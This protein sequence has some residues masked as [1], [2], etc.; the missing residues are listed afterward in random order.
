MDTNKRKNRIQEA[1]YMMETDV[2]AA[3]QRL[4]GLEPSPNELEPEE[5]FQYAYVLY[6][7]GEVDAAIPFFRETVCVGNDKIDPNFRMDALDRLTDY[8]KDSDSDSDTDFARFCKA[9]EVILYCWW[10]QNNP[11]E[12]KA[13][14]RS[15]C[16]TELPN[17]R[18]IL[19]ELAS[20]S[21]G[22]ALLFLGECYENGYRDFEPNPLTALAYYEKAAKAKLCPQPTAAFFA[23][24]LYFEGRG[25]VTQSLKTAKKLFEQAKDSPYSEEAQKY[26]DEIEEAAAIKETPEWAVRLQESV[27]QIKANQSLSLGEFAELG[28]TL[29]S[30]FST[31]GSSFARLEEELGSLSEEQRTLLQETQD[32]LTA[33]IRAAEAEIEHKIDE[34]HARLAK[35]IGEQFSK[36]YAREVES[37]SIPSDI[38]EQCEQELKEYMGDNYGKLSEYS[39]TSLLSAL[40][41]TEQNKGISGHD[42]LDYSGAVIAATSALE[43]ELQ[44]RLYWPLIVFLRLNGINCEA[45]PGG[46]TRT[47]NGNKV[48]KSYFSLGDISYTYNTAY[49]LGYRNPLF[50]KSFLEV[51]QDFLENCCINHDYRG[52]L[53]EQVFDLFEW[54]DDEKEKTYYEP[55]ITGL[56]GYV[57]NAYRNKAA[58]AESLRWDELQSCLAYLIGYGNKTE[59]KTGLMN[60]ILTLFKEGNREWC[61]IGRKLAS[62]EHGD[63]KEGEEAFNE[64]KKGLEKERL[65]NLRFEDYY[66]DI[67]LQ[68][69]TEEPDR[70]NEFAGMLNQTK[71]G[72]GLT[73][74]QF[75]C[76]SESTIK[77]FGSIK[78][79]VETIRADINK[80][81]R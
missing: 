71:Y 36:N 14:W 28:E 4:E 46:L 43:E 35:E 18:E 34:D 68:E 37:G 59:E 42:R 52:E 62:K 22:P 74:K 32:S 70:W 5:Q 33:S 20:R 12:K 6:R 67:F 57:T 80:K 8:Y 19:K 51:L 72:V 50:L 13:G 1:Y 65:P 78:T 76:I 11:R 55:N 3:L 39:K 81:L 24:K 75:L 9:K 44:N 77:K 64:L 2:E 26:L 30:K 15:W 17:A 49:D 54:K 31:M 58:H 56:C 23:G 21:Y 66:K 25:G 29:R 61:E 60:L 10:V 7:N 45:M 16:R 38:I 63:Q 41:Y 47:I 53:P 79:Q 69:H 73:V 27:D 40:V 48:L